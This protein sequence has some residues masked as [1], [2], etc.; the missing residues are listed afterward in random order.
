MT[1]G[2]GH[3]KMNEKMILPN[4]LVI[5]VTQGFTVFTQCHTEFFKSVNEIF[6]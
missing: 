1:F 3:L 6:I 2:V 4:L 5:I